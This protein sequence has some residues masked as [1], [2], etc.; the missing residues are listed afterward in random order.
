MIS[1][2]TFNDPL[3]GSLLKNQLALEGIESTLFNKV[4]F[5]SAT[6]I[7]NSTVSVL[8]DLRDEERAVEIMEEISSKLTD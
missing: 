6:K 2:A 3:T 8:I 7:A 4:A 5:N 1:I